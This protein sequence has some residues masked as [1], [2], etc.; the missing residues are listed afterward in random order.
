M[1]Q[2][3]AQGAV[4]DLVAGLEFLEGGR[5]LQAQPQVDRNSDDHHAGEERC[6]EA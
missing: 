5:L 1:V 3:L 4:G 2:Q 6:P